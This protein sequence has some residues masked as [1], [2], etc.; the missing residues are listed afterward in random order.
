MTWSSSRV[1]CFCGEKS[2]Q[3]HKHVV[4]SLSGTL[5]VS[6]SNTKIYKRKTI[7]WNI[8]SGWA[9]D[10]KQWRLRSDCCV[11][12]EAPWQRSLTG[13]IFSQAF[14]NINN[15]RETAA[16]FLWTGFKP[17]LRSGS[18]YSRYIIIIYKNNNNY[19]KQFH[20]DC[21][22]RARTRWQLSLHGLLQMFHIQVL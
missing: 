1:C 9:S 10:Q 15:Q 21:C 22:W 16:K 13:S 17:T 5:P 12:A 7:N 18:T 2:P 20:D 4:V 3:R 19:N 6:D 11:N 8:M 14:K